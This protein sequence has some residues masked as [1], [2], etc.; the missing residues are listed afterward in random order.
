MQRYPDVSEVMDN[1]IQKE[2]F[3]IPLY[4]PKAMVKDLL[5]IETHL[6]VKRKREFF[7]T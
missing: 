1:F 6:F 3:G 7:T 5:P 4:Q 2:E